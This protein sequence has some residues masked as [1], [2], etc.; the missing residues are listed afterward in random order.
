MIVTTR[1]EKTV[2][3]SF[4]STRPNAEEIKAVRIEDKNG[5]EFELWEGETLLTSYSGDNSE[6][7]IAA[8]VDV[9]SFALGNKT[10]D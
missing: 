9:L 2:E 8:I 1:T 7:Q 4:T 3:T 6:I 5:T 10:E